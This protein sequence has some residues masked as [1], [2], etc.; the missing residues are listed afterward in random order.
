MDTTFAVNP[1][2]PFLSRRLLASFGMTL[3]ALLIVAATVGA[4]ILPCTG[5]SYVVTSSGP[6]IANWTDTSGGLWSPGGSYPGT[7]SC[8]SATDTS[9]AP[10][11]IVVDSVIPNALGSLLFNCGS[12]VIDIQPGGQ[13][14]LDGA[15]TLSN[16]AILQLSGG[17][18]VVN[19]P[20]MSGGLSFAGGS[21]LHILSGTVR[22]SGLI[23]INWDSYLIFD[24]S[25]PA[26][27][28]GVTL[29]NQGY[30][31]LEP[32]G[33]TTVTLDNS[34]T[35][36]NTGTI[37][38]GDGL[39]DVLSGSGTNV[40]NTSSN[41]SVYKSGPG[42][43]TVH[44]TFNVNAG[45]SNVEVSEGK[46]NLTDGTGEAPFFIDLNA[47]LGFPSGTYTMTTG[48]VISG[49]GALVVSGGYLS[50]GGVT[51]PSELDLDGGTITGA[52]FLS[53]KKTLY[54]TG[55][56]L[57][58]SGG[59]EL[60]GGAQGTITGTSGPMLL[61]G[62]TFNNYGYI[63]YTA[64]ANS[65]Q[66]NNSAVFTTYGTFDFQDDASITSGGSGNF[67]IEPN[68]VLQKS[69]GTGLSKI[70]PDSNNNSTVWV[71]SGTLDFSGDG[72]HNG[73]FGPQG[74]AAVQF[75]GNETFT[76]SSNISGPG[77]AIFKAG[78]SSVA[79]FYDI[80]G[81]TSIQNTASVT[82]DRAGITT[83]L[84]FSD[85][86][87]TLNKDFEVRNGGTWS[88]G[89]VSGSTGRLILQ[90]TGT[91]TIN[92]A[93][94]DPRVNGITFVNDGTVEYT[95]DPMG[96]EFFTLG[97]GAVLENNGIF[98]LQTD[99]PIYSGGF[100]IVVD[101]ASKKAAN[102]ASTKPPT[103]TNEGPP[104]PPSRI[105][106]AGTFKKTGGTGTSRIEPNVNNSANVLAQSGTTYFPGAYTQ[107]NG[108]TTLGPGNLKTDGTLTINGGVLD[109]NGTVTGG[110]YNN[111]LVEP[112]DSNGVPP[113]AGLTAG[114]GKKRAARANN[115]LATGADVTPATG[116]ITVSDY[117]QTAAGE[118]KI[119]I[120]GATPGSSY[121]VLAVVNSANLDGTFTAT[122][123]NGYQPPNGTTF[124]VLTYSSEGGVFATENLPTY[125]VNGSLVS[126]Y[127]PM[128]YTLTAV[129][130][131]TSADLGIGM[132]GPVMVNAGSPLSYGITVTN[133]GPNTSSGTI[134]VVD[135]LP[136]GATGASG[137]GGGWS[138]GAPSGSTITCTNST[139]V[140]NGGLLPTLTIS[141]TAPVSG[142]T[143]TNSATVSSSADSNS[144]NDSIST[145]TNVVAV[146]DLQISK[147]GPGGVTAGQN[148]VYTVTVTN[149][150]PSSAVGVTVTDP[151]PANLTFVSNSGACTGAYP[152][153]LGTLI[154]GQSQTITST[155]S[156][157]PMFSG[158]VSNTATVS[159]STNDPSN[160]NDSATA[161]TNV[162]AQADLSIVKTGPA[163]TATGQDISFT[164]VVT[165]NG[166]SPSTT[167][168][169]SDPTPVGIA[170]VSNTGA[171]TTTFP[172][173]LGTLAAGQSA[174]I[175][176]TY[177]V[178]PN[179]AG[180]SVSNTATVSSAINDPNNSDNS[181]TAVT[182]V[183][184]QADV[185]IAKSG[186][187]MAT[188]GQNITYTVTVTNAGPGAAGSIS[189]TDPT[190]PGLTF[191]SNAGSCTGAYPCN[192]G[193]LGSGQSATI[194]TTYN[195]PAGYMS[196]SITNTATVTSGASD[197]NSANNSA[198]ASTAVTAQADLG[199]SKSGPAS[200]NVNQNITY[201]VT[202][203]NFGLL[204]AVNSF[205]SDSTPS[206]LTFVSNSG[207]CTGPYPCMLGTIGA[208]QSVSIS[209]TYSVPGNYPGTT[210]TN[211]ASV[212]TSTP[213]PNPSNDSASV[214]TNRSATV[215]ADLEISKSGMGTVSENTM[216]AFTITVVNHGPAAATNVTVNDPTPPG[217]TFVS[218][219]GACTTPFPCNIG[220]LA[221]GQSATIVSSYSVP[222]QGGRFVT[223]TASVSSSE[224]DP[225]PANNSSAAELRVVPV[226]SCPASAPQAVTPALGS[227]VVSP[228]TFSWSPVPNT[229]GYTLTI[230]GPSAPTP[231]T[232]AGT[233]ALVILPTGSFTWTVRAA[234][235][236]MCPSLTS[237]TSSFNVCNPLTAP[238]ASVIALSTTGQTYSVQW[239][240]LDG[241]SSYEVQES[242]TAGFGTFT[243]TIINTNSKA[244]TKDV[245]A[246]T[247]FF[248]RVRGISECSQ[249][250]GPFSPTLV[251]VVVPLPDPKAAG[252]PNLNAEIGS[253]TPVTFQVFIPGLP[254]G[255]TSFVA[256]T[257][258]PW[259]AV[260][261]TSGLIPPEGFLVTVSEDPSALTNGTWT[262][263]VIVVY[264]TLTANK[265]GTDGVTTVSI[266]V[267][268][269]IVT[270]VTPSS[271]TKPSGSA[272][273]IPSVGH[274]AGSSGSDWRS[275]L[276]IANVSSQ[277]QKYMLTFNRGAGDDAL[278]KSL[279][280]S[281]DPGVTTALDDVVRNWY[282][283]GAL[284]DS[285]NGVLTL[286]RLDN[287]GKVIP[288]GFGSNEVG[289]AKVT[290]AASRTYNASSS[291]TLGQFIPAVGFSNFIG[292]VAGSGSG[293]P[294]LSIQQIAQSDSYRTN[295]GVVEG[296]GKAATVLV[297][298]FNAAGSKLL[299]LPLS[300]AAGEQKQLNSFLAGKIN[301]ALTNGRV[302][303]KVTT[304]EGQVTAYASVIDNLTSDPLLISGVP[305]GGLGANRFVLP[306]IADLSSSS[307]SWRSDLRLFNGGAAPQAAT[308]TFYPNND[309]ASKV[310][311]SLTINPGEVRAVDNVL[312][313]LFGLSNAGGTVHVTTPT[314]APLIV[315]A[316]TYDQTTA[317]TLGQFIPAVT[318]ADAVGSTDV[319]LSILQ[320]EE[321]SRYRTNVGVA[322]VTGKPAVVDISVILPDSKVVPHLS[323]PLAAFESRQ[324]AV[325]SN[326]GL[327]N[328]YNAR[329]AV[330][331]TSGDGKV[332]AYGSV[333]DA[334]TQ[335]P[336]YVPAQ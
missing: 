278:V 56:T 22:G 1:P 87:L 190:P 253:K 61:D 26:T 221:N 10:R 151:T 208:G 6:S 47:A 258:K 311:K 77:S 129:V 227:T 21:Q 110:V 222:A 119:K 226:I 59:S 72:V 330:K 187:A 213:D 133:N 277:A 241:A 332:T 270:P 281:L 163:S 106:N 249:A 179:Y 107:T 205:V 285:S 295:L 214:T 48:G 14:T 34:A 9:G 68:G 122:L 325:I 302:E 38:F 264:G 273:V 24:G 306:G 239:P 191:V 58:G 217:L 174:T 323:V 255:T 314:D 184:Q 194:S 140:T 327:G 212:S 144:A 218:N 271:L 145:M 11:T 202:V 250:K 252:T 215:D 44:V 178:P 166:P 158:N 84:Q 49:Q 123:I 139:A 204:P 183:S 268:I 235:F 99:A 230:N 315:T 74:E 138:C 82:F 27:F 118:L 175:T 63:A 12:C 248:Y 320:A 233:S 40:I 283:T 276:R 328:V 85:G 124:N 83:F 50:I 67:N 335:D 231:I 80:G 42:T 73:F 152:C 31:S 219:S 114:G 30:C 182:N 32:S 301:G 132:T 209:S 313:S 176:S 286:Q 274:I 236:G 316:R 113:P 172:C 71:F 162:G 101:E 164:I 43:T 244:F 89:T 37:T 216:A 189:V 289:A 66:L 265:T 300:L 324:I 20:A 126:S 297:S 261:P 331:V 97:N 86:N 120:G 92:N 94:C 257:D 116:T 321:S 35:I 25:G 293:T 336:T 333:I 317:G 180:T 203:T 142:G 128:A 137:S 36:T 69:G 15:G 98:D 131:P 156:T 81:D 326:L 263:T 303:V 150:G 269:S 93:S 206:G 65:L 28:D 103:G 312:Q 96:T 220:T 160:A 3:A 245:Q 125:P 272:L 155:Y 282:G 91:L 153:N 225:V 136:A 54:W 23:D 309:P 260:T 329:I 111:S 109:G 134:T 148:V 95:A 7:T 224:T 75:C 308:L 55:G 322:E 234:G 4:G 290:I 177:T 188:P 296:A 318:V 88:G 17:T 127:N 13:L 287:L 262:G 196:P 130:A 39:T 121:D 51:E 112:G 170:F 146:A 304:G 102:N 5:T 46:L 19:S 266:P 171:C 193:T 45:A 310:S 117:V 185:S 64:I 197:P 201:T 237:P 141:M 195:I 115:S 284:G 161:M 291:G 168:T 41:G 76:S 147:S 229:T 207:A 33:S 246:P 240:G 232:T 292:R 199:I 294:T 18:L 57:T 149:N 154:S 135:T 211:T 223:N 254:G 79:G 319:P 60:A 165:N 173:N 198:S 299:D 52:G 298:V 53:V 181:S 186:P 62:R 279:N 334:K 267:S 8:D 251:V 256:T 100:V 90:S 167:T 238:A 192:L 104:P 2:R 280:L 243:S 259:L 105:D 242:P 169:V 29:R 210:V 288:T 305:L 228:V 143:I 70:D 200:F 159:S 108:F 307:A 157:S 247:P 78:Y 16:G 275:D